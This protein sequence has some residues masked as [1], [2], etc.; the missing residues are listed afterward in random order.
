MPVTLPPGVAL[1]PSTST[2]NTIQPTADLPGLSV[3]A[4]GAGTAAILQLQ[5]A[6]NTAGTFLSCLNANGAQVLALA[7]QSTKPTFQAMSQ[8]NL[9]FAGFAQTPGSVIFD[10]NWADIDYF[11][12][13]R[14][15]DTGIT[16]N[17]SITHTAKI[18]VPAGL[19]DGYLHLTAPNGMQNI[20][21][22]AGANPEHQFWANS[23]TSTSRQQADIQAVW[24]VNTDATRQ[25]RLVLSAVDYNAPREGLRIEADGTNARVGIKGQA[26][27][28]WLHVA[29]GA[30]GASSAPFK[31]TT[32]TLQSTAEAGAVEFA[33]PTFYATPVTT[34]RAVPGVSDSITADTTVAN[35]AAETTIFTGTVAANEMAAGKTFRV[36]LDGR[37][38]GLVTDT[39]TMRFKVGGTTFLTITN[40]GAAVANVLF[41][42]EFTVTC[43][44]TGAAGTVISNA[45]VLA[46]NLVFSAADTGTHTLDTTAAE[47]ITVTIQWS[48]ASGSDTLTLTQGLMEVLA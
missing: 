26:P 11:S 7:L 36:S 42:A 45:W 46:N 2:Q 6:N 16:W 43:R 40:T 24:A 25:G 3:V 13:L 48:A 20:C 12:L 31:L 21:S 47:N 30:A 22:A 19:D 14:L 34:R 28:A 23:S 1:R 33:T 18:I 41:S 17:V 10:S 8:A 35:S 15:A 32:G 9:V 5:T 27:T 37:Y 4:Q 44:T 29:A 38:S 39:W